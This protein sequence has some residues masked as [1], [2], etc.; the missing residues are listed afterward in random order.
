MSEVRRAGY[1]AV[2]GRPNVGKSTLINTLVGA[3]VSI[4]S[5]KPQTTRHRVLGVRT[6]GE[7]QFVFVDTPGFQTQHRN[8]LN[9]SM[10]RVVTQAL[11][12][13]DLVLFL[14]E[15]MKFTP[16]DERVIKLL[17]ANT[18]VILVVNKVD[19]VADKTRLLPFLQQVA[20]Q[21]G[22]AEIVPLSA[23]TAKDG[24]RLLGIVGKYLPESE[25]FFEDDAITDRS[26]RFLAAEIVRE[27]VF[28]L[29][30]DEIPYGVAVEIEKYET[31]PSGMRRI[32]AV[33]WIERDAHKPI[34]LGKGGEHL[35]RISTEAR[36]DMEKLFDAKVFLQCWVKVK[37]GW[38]D[39]AALLRSLGH[40]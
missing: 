12:E 33:I 24:D 30:G 20:G 13:V 5:S 28:R 15:S 6:E 1:I 19:Q 31:E 16:A 4:V 8:A 7:A 40:D 29:T 36:Q 38:T 10:N 14:I 34:L 27:K 18:P 32:N 26:E 17:P 9:Q 25:P 37:S 35:K 21:F 2:V 3:K 23:L 39:N 22:F 11:G